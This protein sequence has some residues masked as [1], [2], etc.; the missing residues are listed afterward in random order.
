MEY[1][2]DVFKQVADVHSKFYYFALKVHVFMNI[3]INFNEDRLLI[4]N[5]MTCFDYFHCWTCI[6][7]DDL[8]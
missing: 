3:N 6:K 7:F 2:Y 1:H 4:L 5:L 8:F